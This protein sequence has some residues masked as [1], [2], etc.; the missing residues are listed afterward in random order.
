V[1]QNDPDIRQKIIQRIRSS[2]HPDHPSN[3]PDQ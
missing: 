2:D 3:Q 1:A